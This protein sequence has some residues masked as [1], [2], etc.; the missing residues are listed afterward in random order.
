VQQS[1]ITIN[2]EDKVILEVEKCE[3]YTS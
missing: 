3:G 2:Q 1:V